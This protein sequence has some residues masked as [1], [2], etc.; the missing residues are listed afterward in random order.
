[1]NINECASCT[2]L[3][4]CQ[5]GR[6]DENECRKRVSCSECVRSCKDDG[7]QDHAKYMRLPS[8][9]P[10]SLGV[11]KSR[12][13]TTMCSHPRQP[14]GAGGEAM[15]WTISFHHNNISKVLENA[16]IAAIL[17]LF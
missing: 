12:Q 13:A 7:Q 5:P 4:R 9:K 2:T 16:K 15:G 10:A 6:Q 14:S 1:M 8:A 17:M 3:A 11:G